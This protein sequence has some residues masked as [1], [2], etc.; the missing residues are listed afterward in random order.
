MSQ[1]DNQYRTSDTP[2]ASYL[3]T[4]NFNL[5]SIDYSQ[6]RFEFI[7]EDSERLRKVANDYLIGIAQT[8]PAAFSRV[9]KK[10]LRIIYKRCQWEED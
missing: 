3:K 6:S 8:D 9:N 1:A 10:L 5:I 7:F 2:L 4:E